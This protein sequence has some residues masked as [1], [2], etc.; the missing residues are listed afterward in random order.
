M[1]R[2]GSG[3]PVPS[4]GTSNT[5]PCGRSVNDVVSS[6]VSH[7]FQSV[8]PPAQ[9]RSVPLRLARRDESPL[10]RVELDGRC[11]TCADRVVGV[12]A[13]RR[14]MLFFVIAH[15]THAPIPGVERAHAVKPAR[16]ALAI[17]H[18]VAVPAE[19]HI[20]EALGQPQERKAGRFVERVDERAIGDSAQGCASTS[21]VRTARASS[22]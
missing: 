20:A 17:G 15:E 22:V 21:G 5:Y 8:I 16:N 10:V 4:A 2:I 3:L 9:F 11:S 7:E 14:S 1:S 19:G 6:H 18:D 12:A 13:E